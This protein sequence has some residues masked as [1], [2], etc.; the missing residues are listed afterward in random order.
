MQHSAA[1]AA[2]MG[3]LHIPAVLLRHRLPASG[4]HMHSC[5]PSVVAAE[6]QLLHL[7]R[8][9]RQYSLVAGSIKPYVHSRR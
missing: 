2:G 4:S 8:H 6:L 7:G 1:V 9:L 5:L 3:I